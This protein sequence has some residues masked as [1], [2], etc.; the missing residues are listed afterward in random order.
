MRKISRLQVL[1]L[2]LLL[3][4]Q[5]GC[6]VLGQ[7]GTGNF[8][9]EGKVVMPDGTAAEDVEVLV[10]HIRIVQG[11]FGPTDKRFWEKLQSRDGMFQ[12]RHFGVYG[13]SILALKPGYR[14]HTYRFKPETG[15][16]VR[17]LI[18]Q[19][20]EVGE[21]ADKSK[22][23]GGQY[24]LSLKPEVE[25]AGIKLR[26]GKVFGI[27]EA[28]PMEQADF[29]F[30]RATRKDAEGKEVAGLLF[31]AKEG[32]GLEPIPP[33]LPADAAKPFVRFIR[34]WAIPMPPQEGYKLREIWLPFRERAE[35]FP[36]RYYFKTPEGKYGDV[37]FWKISAVPAEGGEPSVRIEVTYTL[38][39]DGTRNLDVWDLP[40]IFD[41][42]GRPM[43]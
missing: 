5:S 39:P 25:T 29:Y 37:I 24:L 23:H 31:K 22:L 41:E 30:E 35:Q 12:V 3:L 10:N 6:A 15:T 40:V 43:E 36:P 7:P 33:L 1:V 17:G 38:Q 32:F 11:E 26:P 9:I 34:G 27:K 42:K 20:V 28:V 21:R 13:V 16:K 18:V 8:D 2:S 19:L 14:S 4:S